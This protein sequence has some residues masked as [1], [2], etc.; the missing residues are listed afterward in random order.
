M[1]C[2]KVGKSNKRK[3]GVCACKNAYEVCGSDGVTYTNDCELRAASIQAKNTKQAEI[4]QLHKGLCERA[5]S[6]VTPPKEIWN[7]T[8]AQVYLSCE[9]IG[10]PT[11]VLTW[12]KVVETKKGIEKMELLPGDRDNL[13]I[14]TRG[15]PQKHEVTGWVLISPLTKNEAGG[16]E[17]HALNSKGVAM[18]SGRINV[19]DSLDEIPSS[20]S[21]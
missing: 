8:G 5:P 18:A 19:V 12:K 13:A 2:V 15:G 14:Q 7:V 20:K 6:V 11:P 9:V 16:Y 17:C 1:E 4:T 3:A 10:I 21:K